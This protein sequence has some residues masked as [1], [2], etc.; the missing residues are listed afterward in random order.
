MSDENNFDFS[1]TSA[2]TLDGIKRANFENLMVIDDVKN[3][4]TEAVEENRW[5]EYSTEWL[6]DND[7]HDAVE[8]INSPVASLYSTHGNETKEAVKEN[9]FAKNSTGEWLHEND[10]NDEC[11]TINYSVATLCS[12]Q[13][14]PMF[15]GMV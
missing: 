11:D 4:T 6:H 8:S 12:N 10:A 1:I 13:D 9:Q 5:S 14:Y 7:A 15:A 3:E 2:P